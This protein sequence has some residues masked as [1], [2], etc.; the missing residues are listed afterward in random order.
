MAG[1][2]AR[3]LAMLQESE[4]H[5]D[6]SKV[7]QKRKRNDNDNCEDDSADY[8]KSRGSDDDDDEEV[9]AQKYSWIGVEIPKPNGRNGNGNR[10]GFSKKNVCTSMGIDEEKF[11]FIQVSDVL[12]ADRV[13]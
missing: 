12:S 10:S 1:L 11:H 6:A 9:D 3:F 4:D 5:Q 7:T 13:I 2:Q 8:G